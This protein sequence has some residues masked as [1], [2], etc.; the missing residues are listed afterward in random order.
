MRAPDRDAVARRLQMHFNPKA[1][2]DTSQVKDARD[3]TDITW[4]LYGQPQFRHPKGAQTPSGL[5]DYL[6]FSPATMNNIRQSAHDKTKDT[7]DETYPL[8]SN[9][10]R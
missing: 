7:K 10:R 8:K 2:L 3:N 5:R 6:T 4:L 9:R 1:K